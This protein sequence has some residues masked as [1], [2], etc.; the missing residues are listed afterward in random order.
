MESS[1]DRLSELRH[2]TSTFLGLW[3]LWET[4]VDINGCV[5]YI[6]LIY[7]FALTFVLL[8]M[9][10]TDSCRGPDI[11]I[12]WLTYAC[13]PESCGRYLT[14]TSAGA[15]GAS[16]LEV[17]IFFSTPHSPYPMSLPRAFLTEVYTRAVSFFLH[18]TLLDFTW[19]RRWSITI[20]FSGACVSSRRGNIRTTTDRS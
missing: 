20:Y 6:H 14:D 10:E 19:H 17:S 11:D 15:L 4:L 12:L 13:M 2:A 1:G 18:S 7:D 3:N 5:V 9:M 16:W 8:D